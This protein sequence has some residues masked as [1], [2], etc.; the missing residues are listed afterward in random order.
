MAMTMRVGGAWRTAVS[1]PTGA[2]FGLHGDG[3]TVD[4]ISG[5][6]PAYNDVSYDTTNK[7]FGTASFL[8]DG[9]VSTQYADSELWNV[10]SGNFYVECW[11]RSTNFTSAYYVF[12]QNDSAGDPAG[13]SFDLQRAYTGS[14]YVGRV[15]IG[16]TGYNV[17]STTGF[18]TSVWTHLRFGRDGGYIR[19]F[20]NGV[21]EASTA[22][23]GAINNST[24]QFGV[25][26]MG[27]YQR[28]WR[29][30]IDEFLFV[31]GQSP[32]S[33]NFTPPTQAYGGGSYVN[34]G[35][36]WKPATPSVKVGGVWKSL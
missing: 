5:L 29:G 35:G 20:V 15:C 32:G 2:V 9:G 34:V 11:A 12:G 27:V 10:G 19:L 30:N 26:R 28:P 13:G 3:N 6:S 14:K 17:S 24:Q 23:S 25:G 22:V 33:I 4:Y 31:K 1:P 7:K 36:V 8:Y 16:G 21:L 18:T